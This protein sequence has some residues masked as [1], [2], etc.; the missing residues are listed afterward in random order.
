[1]M[2]IS[3]KTKPFDDFVYSIYSMLLYGMGQ[4]DKA[5]KYKN[6]IKQENLKIDLQKIQ[7]LSESSFIPNTSDCN[8]CGLKGADFRK[9]SRC[10]VVFWTKEVPEKGLDEGA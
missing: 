7:S 5:S 4:T 6:K 9:W 8:F 3:M 1:M 10:K 2:Q